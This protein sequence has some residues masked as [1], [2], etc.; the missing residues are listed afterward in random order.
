MDACAAL[1]KIN[2]SAI[3]FALVN[4]LLTTG[5]GVDYIRK[6]YIKI[7]DKLNIAFA[8]LII[9]IDEKKG[10]VKELRDRLKNDKEA[11]EI[12]DNIVDV[13]KSL[14]KWK[15]ESDKLDEWERR[16]ELW[17]SAANEFKRT[18]GHDVKEFLAGQYGSGTKLVRFFKE[19]GYNG[20][21]V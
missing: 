5:Y 11:V 9:A 17:K 3:Y 16:G 4:T 8:D 18:T 13:Y 6:Q 10:E 12:F 1:A 7:K 15:F 20:Q 14:A 19:V 21:N 2:D